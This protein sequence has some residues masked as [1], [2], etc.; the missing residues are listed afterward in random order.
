M[1]RDLFPRRSSTVGKK[2]YQCNN[3]KAKKVNEAEEVNQIDTHTHTL[4]T[5]Y[6][7]T[8]YHYYQNLSSVCVCVFLTIS[9]SLS[10]TNRAKSSLSKA[11]VIQGMSAKHPTPHTPLQVSSSSRNFIRAGFLYKLITPEGA[12]GAGYCGTFSF[13]VHQCCFALSLSLPHPY[14]FFLFLSAFLFPFFFFNFYAPKGTSDGI[15]KLHR[16]SV[17]PLQIVSQR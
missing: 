15:L 5:L 16:P 11:T 4:L 3:N 12:G 6:I 9:L 17:R 10:L 14:F 2:I 13:E 8:L 7:A 1:T